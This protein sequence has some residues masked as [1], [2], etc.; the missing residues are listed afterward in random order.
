MEQKGRNVKPHYTKTKPPQHMG[1]SDSPI[2]FLRGQSCFEHFPPKAPWENAGAREIEPAYWSPNQR[3]S[4]GV[5]GLGLRPSTA[6]LPLPQLQGP[7]QPQ[8]ACAERVRVGIL[9]Y[10]IEIC[11][12]KYKVPYQV[13]YFRNGHTDSF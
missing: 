6:A 1:F 12:K 10:C 5:L 8:K 7:A 4:F 13:I 3:S 9:G 11:F 2:Y